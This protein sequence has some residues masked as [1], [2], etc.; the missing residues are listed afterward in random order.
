[1]ISDTYQSIKRWLSDNGLIDGY[2]LQFRRWVEL[3]KAERYIVIRPD[4][5]G[6][7][8]Q[9]VTN[10]YFRIAV[11]SAVNDKNI[12]EVNDHADRIRQIMLDDSDQDCIIFMN[13]TGAVTQFNTQDD[14]FVFELTVQMII[15]R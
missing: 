12:T 6:S 3:D 1:M 4:G 8:N 5:G 13:P 10:D 11:I 7:A 14:R 9:A 15:S 2:K